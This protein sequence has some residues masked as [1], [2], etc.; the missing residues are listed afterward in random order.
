M[1]AVFGIEQLRDLRERGAN[2]RVIERA[3]MRGAGA[4]FV[5]EFAQRGVLCAHFA[6]SR[7]P[8]AAN[9]FEH[10]GERRHAVARFLGEIRACI[11]RSEVVRREEYGQ[12]PAAAATRQRLM[13]ELVN[14]VDIG[15]FLTINLYTNKHFVHQPRSRL[16]FEAFV[17][18]DVTPMAGAV[19]DREQDRLVLC[20]RFGEGLGIP[21]PPIDRIVGVLAQI[22]TGFGG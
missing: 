14:L 21:R 6:A 3:G 8:E 2:R 19:A 15:P 9:L 20:A 22:R 1:A 18:N 10:I 13:G 12:R 16:V 11:E 4:V 17:R 5:E 7:V